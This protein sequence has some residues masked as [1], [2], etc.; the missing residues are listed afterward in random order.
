M[1]GNY[2]GN[3]RL[4]CGVKC[5][6]QSGL[7]KNGFFHARSFEVEVELAMGA[8]GVESA[9]PFFYGPNQWCRRNAD[10]GRGGLWLGLK[11]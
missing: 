7:S 2:F 1:F 8:V 11:G 5:L 4:F 6:M 10:A 9:S 3:Q